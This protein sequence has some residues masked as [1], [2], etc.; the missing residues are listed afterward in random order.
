MLIDGEGSIQI[1]R[2]VRKSKSGYAMH[3]VVEIS[4]T[5][6]RMMKWLRDLFGGTVRCKGDAPSPRRY[7]CFKWQA[8]G[9]NAH[10]ILTKCLPYFIIKR[11]QAETAIAFRETVL[12]NKGR[13]GNSEELY[14]VQEML[15][16]K[17][18]EQKTENLIPII[19]LGDVSTAYDLLN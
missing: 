11:G 17:L 19:N 15:H 2:G 7:I 18:K 13:V 14:A 1:Q 8:T 12:I 10:V 16:K 5:D 3:V 6:P 9:I 4:N